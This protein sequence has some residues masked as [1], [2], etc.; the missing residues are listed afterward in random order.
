[1]NQ[2]VKCI[3]GV[4]KNKCKKESDNCSDCQEGYRFNEKLKLCNINCSDNCLDDQCNIPNFCNKC[5]QKFGVLNNKC[6]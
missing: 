2:C 6:V 5:I 3:K 1:M 4:C